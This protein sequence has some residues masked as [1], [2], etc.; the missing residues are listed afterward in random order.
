[1]F[2]HKIVRKAWLYAGA[3]AV[4]MTTMTPIAAI[5]D[6]DEQVAPQVEADAE[7]DEPEVESIT[8]TG[9]RLRRDEFSSPAPLTVL[10]VDANRRLGVTS[11]QELLTR[12]TVTS[13]QQI[14]QTL[15]TNAGNSN[16]S[17]APPTGGTGSSNINLRG[18]GPA[19]T[20]I[21][22]NGRRLAASGV[23][24]APEQPDIGLIPFAL[25]ERAE[26]LTEAGSS[27]YG[28]DAVAGTVNIILREDFEGLEVTGSVDIPENG[29]G[30]D[31]QTSLIAGAQGER[32][33]ILFGAEYRDRNRVSA[34][35]RD[36]ATD[37]TDIEISEDGQIFDVPINGFFDSTVFDPNGDVF[38]FSP[39]Q[40]DPTTGVNGFTNCA[41]FAPPEGFE[42][43]G[44]TNFI[45]FPEFN[46]TFERN[47]ADLVGP[48]ETLSLLTLGEYDTDWF[49]TTN[50]FYFEAFY[51]N[52]QNFSIAAIEQIFPTVPGE[53][54]EVDADG[55]V[56]G[57]VDNPLNP[58]NGDAVPVVTLEDIPQNF[59][60]ELQQVRFVGG[61]RGDFG[62]VLGEKNW[63]WDTFFS[64]DR[65]TGFVAQPILFEPNLIASLNYVQQPDGSI[66]CSTAQPNVD[67]FGFFSPSD[68]VVFDIFNDSVFNGGDNGD[69][70]FSTQA[71]EDFLIGN[72]TNRTVVEQ[73]IVNG[74]V[75]GD[76]IEIP[77]GGTMTAGFGFEY[78]Q[79]RIDSQNGLV[80]V[81]SLNVAENPL[82]EGD[83]VGDRDFFEF[84]GEVYLP[85]VRDLPFIERLDV[86][87]AVR[88]TEESNF[89]A[90][91][92]YRVRGVYQP[93]NWFTLSAGWGTS[94]RAPN[95]REQFL[96]DQGGGVSGALDPCIAANIDAAIAAAPD[97]AADP[98][99]Q[100]LI[101]SCVQSGVEFTDSDGDG[102][103]DTTP[104]G[105]TGVTTIGT[106]SGG[107]P[108]LEPETSQTL[109]LG[110]QMQ[111]FWTDAYDL[112]FAISYYNIFIENA[113]A[114]PTAELIINNC[115]TDQE[116]PN[117]TSP[118]CSLITRPD[119]GAPANNIIGNID[120]TFF[121]VAEET[122]SGID[123]TTR[124][125][126]DLADI[127]GNVLD[128]Q[129]LTNATY[130][131]ERDELI[132]PDTPRDNNNTEI[133]FPRL[134]LNVG[135]VLNWGNFSLLSEHRRIHGQQQDDSEGFRDNPFVIGD[136]ATRDLDFVGAVW[137]H[138][139]S[140]SYNVDRYSLTFGVSNITDRAPPLIDD[141]EGPNRNNAVSSVGYDFF[142]RSYFL[143]GRVSF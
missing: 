85:L 86:E 28:A 6:D 93:M 90:D 97:G 58:F 88:Y 127:G 14:D 137:Y 3:S 40:S 29:G 23:R 41:E 115:F 98:D 39:G 4:A 9:S 8:V 81:Q 113:V 87:G 27:I 49:G 62:G 138:D 34:F 95:L 5:A 131:I 72:R 20:L 24:G 21:L 80:G 15:N 78:R 68:C 91:V 111:S 63:T 105:T 47:Q 130:V 31:V 117:L 44:D 106:T 12:S 84:F 55:N 26:V 61:W 79:D 30:L 121:N 112:D 33:R 142:G 104:L 94:F 1:M 11:I 36:F 46:D 109:T 38:C 7:D 118:F 60:V 52:R 42:D 134:L 100:F 128:W 124:F 82:P 73:Y 77:T 120:T 65:G 59:D 25:V 103:L 69:G 35:Q 108:N 13:G 132:F 18:L 133:G 10:D 67:N 89:G 70:A 114:E 136:V 37:L 141:S 107:N 64:Y 125:R 129:L 17:E 75:Q 101:N 110:A 16:A 48:I 139:V 135:S 54:A 74:F 122:S 56:I 51:F 45:Y 2:N 57:M 76:V 19:R 126:I 53:I 92:T 143:T 123:F 119:A 71:E 83:T 22:L 116:F 50:Q 140:I 43:L 99:L 66:T 32:G 102:F 96:A